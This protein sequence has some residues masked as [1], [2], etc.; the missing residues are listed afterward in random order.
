MPSKQQLRRIVEE[1]LDDAMLSLNL[2]LEGKGLQQLEPIIMRLGRNGNL[3]HWYA[4]LKENKTLPNLDGKT[5]GTVLEML[6]VAVLE[7][8]T[9]KG[10]EIPQLSINPARGIDLPILI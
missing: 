6:F 3:P 8:V 10:Q 5:I 7:T 9:F 4:G 2:A 1:N